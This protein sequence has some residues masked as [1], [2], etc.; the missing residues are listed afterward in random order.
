MEEKEREGMKERERER[1]EGEGWQY[2]ISMLGSKIVLKDA[3]TCT[4]M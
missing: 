3:C 2:P 1:R 4:C